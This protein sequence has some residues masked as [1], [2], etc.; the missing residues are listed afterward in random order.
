MD[1]KAVRETFRENGERDSLF[2]RLICVYSICAYK[3]LEKWIIVNGSKSGSFS[4]LK[5]NFKI[6]F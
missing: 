3:R 2:K 4:L 5:T 1:L 6:Y